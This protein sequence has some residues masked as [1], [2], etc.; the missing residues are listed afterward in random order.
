VRFF[1]LNPVYPVENMVEFYVNVV[2]NTSQRAIIVN[3]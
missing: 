1:A 3:V 2:K